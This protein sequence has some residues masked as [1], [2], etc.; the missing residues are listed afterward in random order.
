MSLPP[1][2]KPDYHLPTSYIFVQTA[3][4]QGGAVLQ[5]KAMRQQVWATLIY[6]GFYLKRKSH[7]SSLF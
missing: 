4:G 7:Q 1:L 5:G 2:S 3:L 6:F